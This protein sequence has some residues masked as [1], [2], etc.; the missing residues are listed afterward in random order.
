MIIQADYDNAKHCE[1]I[2]TLLNK[3]A[4]DTMGGGRP[5]T[6]YAVENLIPA[7]RNINGAHSLLAIDK[8]RPDEPAIGLVNAFRGFSTFYAMPLLN[9]HD[10]YVEESYRRQQVAEKLL[11][12]AESI[13]LQHGYC[14]LTLEVLRGNFPARTLYQKLGFV[15][16]ELDT[17]HGAA[18]FLEKILCE[19]PQ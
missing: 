14:K 16:Y 3:Y 9:I 19:I 15:G 12:A 4:L 13:C 5:L 7:L 11:Q 1:S 18:E 10:V 6:P 8:T 2:L 17:E